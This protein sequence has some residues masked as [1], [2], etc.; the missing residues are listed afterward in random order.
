MNGHTSKVM[1]IETAVQRFM[2]DGAHISIGGFTLNRNCSML[3]LKVLMM[4][5]N[6]VKSN[7]IDTKQENT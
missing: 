4:A 1:S 2:S 6:K 3:G 5:K 7:S